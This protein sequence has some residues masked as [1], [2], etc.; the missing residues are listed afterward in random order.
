MP[1]THRAV[2]IV[3][4]VHQAKDISGSITVKSTD[5]FSKHQRESQAITE[6]SAVPPLVLDL[7]TGT[8]LNL[9]SSN[10]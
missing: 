7:T 3:A 1:P 6:I 10:M 8:F 9:M 4:G 5:H 2:D